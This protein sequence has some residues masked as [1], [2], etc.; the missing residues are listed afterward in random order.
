MLAVIAIVATFST[1]S[2]VV[3]HK[4]DQID[5][6]ARTMMSTLMPARSQAIGRGARVTLC[7]IDAARACLMAG[8]SYDGGLTD[9]S[10]GWALFA[11]R[12]GARVLLRMQPAAS[13]I[14][15][16]ATGSELSFTPPSGQVVRGFLQ[17]NGIGQLLRPS[18]HR[19][20]SC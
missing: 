17:G 8:K 3:W 15:I 12:D 16:G 5:A 14:A 13:G 10:C 18:Q 1:P 9:W 2:F 7:R 11:D 20:V 19:I 6:R 4:R